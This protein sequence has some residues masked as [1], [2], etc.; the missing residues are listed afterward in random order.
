M[1]VHNHQM[2]DKNLLL[3]QQLCYNLLLFRLEIFNKRLLESDISHLLTASSFSESI[4]SC[5]ICGGD[6]CSA[7]WP[8]PLERML[9]LTS[10]FYNYHRL[11]SHTAV[12]SS[13]LLHTPDVSSCAEVLPSSLLPP[14]V[15]WRCSILFND[16]R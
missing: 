5:S 15:L 3:S 8:P 16:S 12:N 14:A 1:P 2:T 7:A 13:L 9:K 11:R 4:H 6:T 10:A